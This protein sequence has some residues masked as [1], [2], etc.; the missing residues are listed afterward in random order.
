MSIMGMGVTEQDRAIIG[1]ILSGETDAFRYLVAKYKGL[2]F[3]VVRSMIADS[4]EHEDLAQDILA[5]V[6]E[7]LPTFRFRCGLA[8]WISRIGYNTCLNQLRRVKSRPH[9]TMKYRA[10]G[11]RVDDIT[12]NSGGNSTPVESQTPYSVICRKELDVAVRD[13][14]KKLPAHYRLVVTLY[15]LESFSIADIALSLGIPKGT[16]KSDLFRARAKL[17]D[18]L[19]QKFTIEDLL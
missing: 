5:R 2:A 14:I 19:L 8:T 16:I 13:S 4:S 9:E 12:P 18:D 10:E 1:R 17:K 3:H 15:Y 7:S 6:F 11:Y